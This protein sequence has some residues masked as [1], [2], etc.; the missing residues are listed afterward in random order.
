M[1]LS[2]R[3]LAFFAPLAPSGKAHWMQ[4][5]MLG[6]HCKQGCAT[7]VGS[8]NRLRLYYNAEA[9]LHMVRCCCARVTWSD[10]GGFKSHKDGTFCRVCSLPGGGWVLISRRDPPPGVDSWVQFP[11][12]EIFFSKIWCRVCTFFLVSTRC[13]SHCP[14][15]GHCS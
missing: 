13:R 3:Y 5:C 4:G 11:A 12:L 8:S 14:G 6:L 10:R 2:S 7:G 1:V 15:F 9:V